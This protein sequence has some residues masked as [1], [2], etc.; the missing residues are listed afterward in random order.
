V[1]GF[2]QISLHGHQ[3][4]LP[5]IEVY[6]ALSSFK[7]PSLPETGS[8]YTKSEYT[9]CSGLFTK[10]SLSSLLIDPGTMVLGYDLPNSLFIYDYTRKKIFF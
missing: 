3:A 6:T 10:V 2:S 9:A 1:A 8:Y 4:C 5:F 7:K